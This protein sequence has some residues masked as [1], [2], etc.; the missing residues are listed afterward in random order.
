LDIGR[1][2]DFERGLRQ[3]IEEGTVSASAVVFETYFNDTV[4]VH[5]SV[6]TGIPSIYYER[7]Y[8]PMATYIKRVNEFTDEAL[9]IIKKKFPKI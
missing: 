9:E 1:K 8:P 4:Y 7:S 2:I 5:R 3:L 6:Q